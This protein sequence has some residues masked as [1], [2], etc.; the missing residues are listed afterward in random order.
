MT[1]KPQG[2]VELAVHISRL[3]QRVFDLERE[4][5]INRRRSTAEV[6]AEPPKPTVGLP[7]LFG[8]ALGSII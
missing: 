1:D 2:F 4:V 5:G 6:Y 7:P 3:E 8:S